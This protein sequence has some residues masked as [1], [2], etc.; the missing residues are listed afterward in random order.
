VQLFSIMGIR[1]LLRGTGFSTVSISTEGVNPQEILRHLRGRKTSVRERLDAGC[2]LN[3]FFE[4]HRGRRLAKRA[5][6]KALSAL[7]LGDSLKI[8]ASRSG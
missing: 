2:A 8:L 1:Q 5:I 3:A 6:N 7:T 4:E